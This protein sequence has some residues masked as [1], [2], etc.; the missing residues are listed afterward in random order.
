MFR[1]PF[2]PPKNTLFW[3][4]PRQKSLLSDRGGGEP[5]GKRA[6]RGLFPLKIAHFVPFL[7][8]CFFLPVPVGFPLFPPKSDVGFPQMF[9]P[10]S[11]ILAERT[12]KTHNEMLK[13]RLFSAV[14]SF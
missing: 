5:A 1:E 3:A 8:G 14:F 11:P 2:F 7:G 13:K 4:T 9:T 6:I 10:K 12:P